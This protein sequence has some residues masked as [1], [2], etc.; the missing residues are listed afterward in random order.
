MLENRIAKLSKWVDP[1]LITYHKSKVVTLYE[2]DEQVRCNL[3][4]VVRKKVEMKSCLLYT[5][6][7]RYDSYNDASYR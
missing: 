1:P 6:Q 3:V 4:F 7:N 5:I 2:Q